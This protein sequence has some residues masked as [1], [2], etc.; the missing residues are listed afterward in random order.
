MKFR[1]V[2][3]GKTREKNWRALQEEYLQRLSYFAEYSIQEIKESQ[4]HETREIEGKRILD[5][6]PNSA[7]VVLLDVAGRQLTSLELAEKIESWQNQSLREIVFII[8]GQNGVSREVAQQADLHL[9]LSKMTFTH[10]AARVLLTEQLYRA[11]TIIKNYPY[12]K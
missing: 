3:V 12:Q 5:V 9:S 8:G 10:E 1:F 6:L 4:S 11:F 7:L 2:W